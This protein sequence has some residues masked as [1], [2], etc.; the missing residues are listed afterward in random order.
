MSALF[1]VSVCEGIAVSRGPGIAK[2]PLRLR[3][4][5]TDAAIEKFLAN[6]PS[7]VL[8]RHEF[9]HVLRVF[10]TNLD[11]TRTVLYALTKV[12]GIGRR[13]GDAVI[14]R[15]GV[16]GSKRAGELTVEEVEKLVQVIEN[17]QNYD[18]PAWMLNRRKDYK[19]GKDL[20]NYTNKLDLQLREDLDRLRK[21]RCNRGLRH[22]W[23][24]KVRGQH[25]KSTGRGHRTVVAAK[26]PGKK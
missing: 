12:K 23:G 7:Y 4:G 16:D 8:E 2:A 3:G 10:N 13:F 6:P 21:I 5:D 11:G 17:P 19:T 26:K 1:F 9:N 15:A 18:I 25:T 20:H 22:A 24:F 14:K